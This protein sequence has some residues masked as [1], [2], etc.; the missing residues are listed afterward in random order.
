MRPAAG[1]ASAHLKAAGLASAAT[2]HGYTVAFEWA[3]ALFT[4]GL[5]VALIILPRNRIRRAPATAPAELAI[6]PQGA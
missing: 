4:I 2:I 6:S 5:L 3:A 1:Y